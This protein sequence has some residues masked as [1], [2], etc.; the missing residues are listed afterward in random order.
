M[1]RKKSNSNIYN[2]LVDRWNKSYESILA[3][4]NRL[5]T[6]DYKYSIDF[7]YLADALKSEVTDQNKV[8]EARQRLNKRMKNLGQNNFTT[9]L[10]TYLSC[11]KQLFE[12][13]REKDS[14]NPI[15]YKTITYAGGTYTG[16]VRQGVPHGKGKFSYHNY[17]YEGDF[18]DGRFEGRG[19]VI[20]ANGDK[21]EGDF[22]NDKFEG[23]GTSIFANGDKYEG[24]WKNGKRE[25]DGIKYYKSGDRYEG[26]FKNDLFHG[27]GTYYY[28]YKDT[29]NRKKLTGHWVDGKLEGEA[30]QW[31]WNNSKAI[32]IYSN[33]VPTRGTYY[34]EGGNYMEG[35]FHNGEREGKWRYYQDGELYA[36]KIFRNG[37]Q[38]DVEYI[39][40]GSYSSSSTSSEAPP[41]WLSIISWVIIIIIVVAACRS[42]SS[43]S[44]SRSHSRDK[45]QS[46]VEQTTTTTY[47]CTAKT[48]NVRS[49]ASTS[50]PVIGKIKKGEIVNVYYIS[51]G[52]AKVTYKGRIGYVSEKYIVRHNGY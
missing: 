25:G 4:I 29:Y 22:K 48:L 27:T 38:V 2:T 43:C 35:N 36:Y 13:K 26:Q 9:H 45:K 5:D 15:S 12:Y 44:C 34:W 1:D 16:M 31:W 28:S 41:L 24:E 30:T 51:N 3:E 23:K 10:R 42:C 8:E 19:T 11:G 46:K 33:G 40:N 21:Y 37:E 20:F 7:Y 32:N 39:T 14:E 6:P 50:A 18:K 47:I 17:T 52:F 49:F